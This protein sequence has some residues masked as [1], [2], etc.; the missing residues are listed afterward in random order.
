M[1]QKEKREALPSYNQI[2]EYINN[3]CVTGKVKRQY[4]RNMKLK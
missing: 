4:Y 2:E 1:P 3:G